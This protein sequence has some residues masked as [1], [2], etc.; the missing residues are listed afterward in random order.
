MEEVKNDFKILTAKPIGMR[1]LR[2]PSSPNGIFRVIK[3]RRLK[4]T[5]L[6]ARM[7]EGKN[8]FKILTA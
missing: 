4:C 6:I 5:G 1:L 8:D 7:E 2:R 3:C